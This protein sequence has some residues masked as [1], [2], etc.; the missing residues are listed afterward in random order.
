MVHCFKSRYL[1]QTKRMKQKL[2]DE[3][4]KAIIAQNS[5]PLSISKHE[6][7]FSQIKTEVEQAHS[8]ML[9][10]INMLSKSMF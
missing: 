3:R 10:A 4:V 8:E 9:E 2:Q 1:E 5:T 7:V 6:T